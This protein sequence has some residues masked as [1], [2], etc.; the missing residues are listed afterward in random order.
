LRQRFAHR[1]GRI[2]NWRF[3]K[4]EDPLVDAQVAESRLDVASLVEDEILLSLPLMPRHPE[5]ECSLG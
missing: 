3:G 2:A 1:P 5:G 4:S